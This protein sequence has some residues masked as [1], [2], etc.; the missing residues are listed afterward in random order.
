M[1][2]VVNPRPMPSTGIRKVQL[3]TGIEVV[4]DARRAMVLPSEGL[5][6]LADLH[7]GYSWVQRHRG[8]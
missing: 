3:A 7:L 2:D 1:E 6:A 5:L 4:L 8:P